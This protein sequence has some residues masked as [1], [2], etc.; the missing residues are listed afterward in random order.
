MYEMQEGGVI[1]TAEDEDG[2]G[3]VLPWGS[4]SDRSHQCKFQ[5]QGQTKLN[6]IN[7]ISH[8]QS[9]NFVPL[10]LPQT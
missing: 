3:S 5:H 1:S 7:V 2:G 6:N 10:L 8:G 9:P 4:L